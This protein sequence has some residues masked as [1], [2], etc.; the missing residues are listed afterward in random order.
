MPAPPRNPTLSED[1]RWMR[2]AL[3]L[4][5]RA[6]GRTSPNPMVGAVVVRD[7]REVGTGFHR[8]AGEPHAE[9][10]ALAAAGARARGAALYVTL[11]PCSTWGR[12]PPCT[13]AIIAAGVRRVVV[14]GI[15]PNPKHAGRGIEI[16]RRAGIEVTVGVEQARCAELNEAFFQWI[17]FG[18]PFVLLKLAM[19]LDGRIATAGGDSKWITSAPARRRVQRFR[20]WADAIMVGAETVRLDDPELT[21]RTPQNWP[22]QPLRIVWSRRKDWPRHFRI[23]RAPGPPPLVAAPATPQQWRDFLRRLGREHAVTALLIEG[24]GELAAAAL[25]AGVVDKAAFFFAPKILGGRRS[26]PGI[27]G[28][29][30]VRLDDAIRLRDSRCERVGPDYLV[31]GRPARPEE[32]DGNPGPAPAEPKGSQ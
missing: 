25:R 23:W 30:P 17:R 20:Q 13:E 2:R 7:G 18:R 11:E 1:A 32:T 6:W 24:G 28:P 16:L 8:A 27:A 15:D 14:G 19:T 4:A 31:I 3:R 10:L 21:V 12:T 22:C 5:R 29:D 26:R 9:P